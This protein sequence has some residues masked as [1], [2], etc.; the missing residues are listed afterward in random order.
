[1]FVAG[2]IWG[3]NKFDESPLGVGLKGT[4]RSP[5]AL[6]GYYECIKAVHDYTRELPPL[7]YLETAVF[8][9]QQLELCGHC[10]ATNTQHTRVLADELR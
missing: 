1:M 6:S 2:D 4:A 8:C 9:H 10:V 7:K 3:N 5:V